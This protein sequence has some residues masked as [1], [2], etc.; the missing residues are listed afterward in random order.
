MLF[1]KPL[2]LNLSN[3][4]DLISVKDM[5]KVYRVDINGTWLYGISLVGYGM[6]DSPV[7]VFTRV[8]YNDN[9]TKEYLEDF[10]EN[11]SCIKKCD[12]GVHYI[13][14]VDAAMA[15]TDFVH[16]KESPSVIGAKEYF[17][18]ID[19]KDIEKGASELYIAFSSYHAD[20]KY[21]K[22]IKQLVK[23]VKKFFK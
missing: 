7:K 13:L 17:V 23:K 11:V 20:E 22:T 2:L 4:Y 3:K 21:Q 1:N 19:I 12:S 6:E 14:D 8:R 9:K 5:E 10:V 16:I 18:H 15:N